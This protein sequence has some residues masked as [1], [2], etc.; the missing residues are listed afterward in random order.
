MPI[1]DMAAVPAIVAEVYRLQPARMIELG[2]GFGKFGVLCREVLD[3]MY[4]RCNPDQWER[5][6]HGVEGFA[7]YENPAW[8]CYDEWEIRDFTDPSPA[9]WPLVLMVDSLEHLAPA[10]GSYF[11]SDLVRQNSHVIVSVPLGRM[12]QGATFGNEYECHRTTFQGREF[13][14][15]PG[16]RQLHRGMCLAVSIPG[17]A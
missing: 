14:Q 17:A 5:K 16:V 15:F 12:D 4:G 11:L 2:I 10:R 6:I 8:G 1:S 7:G 9:G 13:D 3:A